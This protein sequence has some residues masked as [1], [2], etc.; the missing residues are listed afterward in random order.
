MQKRQKLLIS[1][2]LTHSYYILRHKKWLFKSVWFHQCWKLSCK[3]SICFQNV[4]EKFFLCLCF[5]SL[6]RYMCDFQ[7]FVQEICRC[8]WKNTYIMLIPQAVQNAIILKQLI[9]NE[10]FNIY[11]VLS[12][13]ENNKW[14]QSENLSLFVKRVFKNNSNL[15][16][17]FLICCKCCNFGFICC[18]VSSVQMKW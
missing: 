12:S 15:L 14:N 6:V 7:K 1:L 5:I 16:H 4:S 3:F 2:K 10:S 9:L 17:Y 18:N 8:K 13:N 11:F